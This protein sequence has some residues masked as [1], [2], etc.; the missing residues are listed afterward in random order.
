MRTIDNE[1]CLVNAIWCA[2]SDLDGEVV[3]AFLRGLS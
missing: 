3:P 2:I 1:H